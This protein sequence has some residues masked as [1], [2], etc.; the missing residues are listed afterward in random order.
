MKIYIV[1]GYNLGEEPT[2]RV[3]DNEQS[4]QDCFDEALYKY[5]NVAYSVDRVRSTYGGGQI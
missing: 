3:F 4:A 1:I 2:V 5:E